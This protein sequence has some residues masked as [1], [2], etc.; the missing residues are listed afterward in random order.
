VSQIRVELQLEDRSFVTG[1]MRAGQSLRDFKSELARTN[2]HFAR[3][4]QQ[5]NATVLSFR[6]QEEATRSFG[7]RLRDVS[8]IAGGAVLAFRALTGASNGILGGVIRINAEMERLRY[9]LAGMST[10]ADPMAEAT[11]Q[12]RELQTLASE[13]PFSLNEI[14]NSFVKLNA[15]GL[16]PTVRTMRTLTDAMAA[17]GASDISLHRVTIALAQMQGKGVLSMEELRQQLGEHMPSALSMFARSMNMT[18][19]EMVK[20]I[21]MGVVESSSAIQGF[22]GEVE[23]SYAGTGRFMMQTFSGQMAR[24]R[25]EFTRL[26]TGE[27]GNGEMGSAFDMLKEKMGDLADFLAGADAAAFFDTVGR[28]L[29]QLMTMMESLTGTIVRMRDF[30]SEWGTVIAYALGGS[31]ALKVISAFGAKL[32]T[33]RVAWEAVA[34]ASRR[35]RRDMIHATTMQSLSSSVAPMAASLAAQRA[36]QNATLTAMTSASV[37]AGSAAAASAGNFARATASMGGMAAAGLRFAGILGPIGLM[38]GGIS[39]IAIE[40]GRSIGLWGQNANEANQALQQTVELERQA[41]LNARSVEAQRLQNQIIALQDQLN[42]EQ[43]DSGDPNRTNPV[44]QAQID[45][46]QSQLNGFNA[47][48]ERIVSQFLDQATERQVQEAQQ[49]IAEATRGIS[50]AYHQQ[51]IA[52]DAEYREA[53]ETAESRGVSVRQVQAEFRIRRNEARIQRQIQLIAAYNEKIENFSAIPENEISLEAVSRLIEIRR[54][55]E[56][57]MEQWS[58]DDFVANLLT[59]VETEEKKTERLVRTLERARERVVDLQAEISGA[60]GEFATLMYRI[61][62]GDFGNFETATEEIVRM[63]DMLI[64]STLAAEVLDGA[65]KGINSTN[66]ELR[67]INENN[68]REL[69]RIRAIRDGVN[70]ANAFE[71]YEWQRQDPANRGLEGL[72]DPSQLIDEALASVTR[73]VDLTRT[74]LVNLGGTIRDD[75]FGGESTRRINVIESALTNVR[76]IANEIREVMTGGLGLSNIFSIL[77]G[78]AGI[79]TGAAANGAGA[80]APAYG[81]PIEGDA[82]LRHVNQGR[83]RPH[84]ISQQLAQAMSFL[85]EMGIVMEV[86]SGGQDPHNRPEGAG[87]RHDHGNAADVMFYRNG[88]QLNWQNQEDIPTYQEIVRR[89]RAAGVTGFGA[90]P[91]YMTPGSMHIGYG[92]PAVWGRSRR[93]DTAPAWLVEAFNQAAPQLAAPLR[94]SLETALDTAHAEERAEFERGRQINEAVRTE[95]P[96]AELAQLERELQARLSAQRA[97]SQDERMGTNERQVRERIANREFGTASQED[98]DRVLALAI[99]AD[100]HLRNV[101]ERTRDLGR[102]E[103]NNERLEDERREVETRRLDALARARDPNHRAQS[104][105]MRRLLELER[106][107]LA[108]AERLYGLNTPEYQREATRLAQQR[109]GLMTAEAAEALVEL[110]D[111]ARDS[112][113][114]VITEQR[115]LRQR[116]FEERLAELAALRDRAIADGALVAEANMLY[117]RAVAAER[118]RLREENKTELQ[119]TLDEMAKYAENINRSTADWAKGLGNAIYE[120]FSDPD[121][122]KNLANTIRES[123]A[124]SLADAAAAAILRPFENLIAGDGTPGSGIGGIFERLINNLM[125]SFTQTVQSAAA[126]VVQGA[127]GTQGG[128]FVGLISKILGKGKGVGVAHTGGIVGSRNLATRTTA[129]ANFIGAPKFHTGGIVGERRFAGLSPTEVPIIAKRGEGVFTEEQMKYLGGTVNNRSISINAPVTVNANGGTPEQNA[130]LARQMSE[131]MDRTMRGIVNQEIMR[132]M[133]PGGMLRG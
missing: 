6:Q 47:E 70:P 58:P 34:A 99:Q 100:E 112:E 80:P 28:G 35:A 44:I 69:L 48:S 127:T 118:A 74:S 39:L 98:L 77:P 81:P 38:V 18:V 89:A 114:S 13:T 120:S 103:T 119:R 87:P 108:I 41:L 105:E 2:P 19:G 133:R 66:A 63:R 49:A 65:M 10:A 9:Q 55:L 15:A 132:Q 21:S 32:L 29:Q 94:A 102:L 46:I 54:G 110:A 96:L 82:W 51:M 93:S 52:M 115:I 11:A 20:L 111:A 92:T 60:S 79:A 22:L 40:I 17:F 106:E 1:V 101:Q 43:F 56:E 50:R 42:Q 72:G 76:N 73:G 16:N 86:F 24:I 67:R 7:Q 71:F 116:E 31:V 75:A 37:A 128:G 126:N 23:R 14:A 3:L 62:R 36:A 83:G 117:E 130:D 78:L 131:Q 121:A 125:G 12:V 4:Q 107:Q 91:G 129:A 33:L 95:G 88:R 113:R 8:I 61:E 57:E 109:A 26:V 90:G 27:T 53:L 123:I 45:Q 84:P 122:F 124:R 5:G 25:T 85:R 97:G 30:F 64:E 59:G 104:S 68:M